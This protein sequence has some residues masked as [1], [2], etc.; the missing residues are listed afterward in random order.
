[1]PHRLSDRRLLDDQ[2]RATI[3]KH[4]QKIAKKHRIPIKRLEKAQTDLLGNIVMPG[5][6][7]YRKAR[8][9][10]NV[11]FDPRPALIIQC[12]AEQDVRIALELGREFKIPVPLRSGGH[13][14]AGYSGGTGRLVIDLKDLNDIAI[15]AEKLT[16][17]VSC[18]TTFG[19]LN[20]ALD[21]RGWHLPAGECDGVRMG[22]FMQ[23]G[24]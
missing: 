12:Q 16:A 20:L 2:I 19:K 11:F 5:D 6:I 17:M 21:A 18:G 23:G 1:M 13:T 7:A 8:R 4:G 24:G 14:T 22:G 10:W 9:I 15:D 3:R